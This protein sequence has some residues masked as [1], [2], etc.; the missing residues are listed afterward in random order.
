MASL[1]VLAAAWREGSSFLLLPKR[2]SHGQ[3]KVHITAV[4]KVDFSWPF[5]LPLLLQQLAGIWLHDLV[6]QVFISQ[7]LAARRPRQ[8]WPE[9]AGRCGIAR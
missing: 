4:L 8:D 9:R 6:F 5:V 2:L 7:R 1:R 3:L